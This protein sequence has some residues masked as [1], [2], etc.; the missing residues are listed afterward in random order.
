MLSP[1]VDHGVPAQIRA[2][3]RRE[4]SDIEKSSSVEQLSTL[5]KRSRGKRRA[6]TKDISNSELLVSSKRGMKISEK[7]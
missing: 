5:K 3:E 4:E 1:I 6:T 2:E 7:N